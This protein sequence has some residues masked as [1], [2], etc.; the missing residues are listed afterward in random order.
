MAGVAHAHGHAN[1]S[2]GGSECSWHAIQHFQDVVRHD[3]GESQG[4]QAAEFNAALYNV[5][6]LWASQSAGPSSV[7]STSHRDVMALL[8]ESFYASARTN[9]STG[10][11]VVSTNGDTVDSQVLLAPQRDIACLRQREVEHMAAR[12][13]LRCSDWTA[14]SAA[15]AKLLGSWPEFEPKQPARGAPARERAGVAC[16]DCIHREYCL[17]LLRSAESSSGGAFKPTT[18]DRA[19]Q[20][21]NKSNSHDD[22]ARKRCTAV[23]LCEHVLKYRPNDVILLLLLSEAQY[24][25]GKF[26]QAL[27]AARLATQTLELLKS[28]ELRH[29]RS[30]DK[31]KDASS[32]GVD[33]DILA[34]LA[35]CGLDSCNPED[36]SG[37]AFQLESL[38]AESYHQRAAVLW[39]L[40]RHDEAIDSHFLAD[41]CLRVQNSK[42][43]GDVGEYAQPQPL[44]VSI[45]G[46]A[47]LQDRVIFSLTLALWAR[48]RCQEA[49]ERW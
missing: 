40:G 34:T 23:A 39:R 11:N 3:A 44:S 20:D 47:E 10:P 24:D 12:A 6:V 25:L 4:D 19:T 5:A 49:A 38:L 36:K 1:S 30:Q 46:V 9:A 8:V 42:A 22:A 18:N 16:I 2:P 37:L 33:D 43:R 45:A 15:Y 48:G 32:C 17:A 27:S 29:G 14:A 41:R 13:A 31:E 7:E 26:E 28:L 35:A 21:G